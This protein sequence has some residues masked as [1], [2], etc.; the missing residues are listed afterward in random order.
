YSP[1]GSVGSGLDRPARLSGVQLVYRA[2]QLRDARTGGV[3]GTLSTSDA[4]DRLLQGSGFSAR[5]DE[6][7]AVLIVPAST[8]PAAPR[9]VPA[10]PASPPAPVPAQAEDDV[11]QFDAMQVTGS[12]IP[13]A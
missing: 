7:G 3:R 1:G 9:S 11:T 4:L 13:P 5:R 2:D 10:R 8:A 6:S 12:R